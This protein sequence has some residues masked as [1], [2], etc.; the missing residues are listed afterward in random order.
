MGTAG[1]PDL[2]PSGWQ[3]TPTDPSSKKCPPPGAILGT[4]AAVNI[5]GS[6]LGVLFGHRKVIE[7][8]SCGVF[9]KQNSRS[10]IYFWTFSV[11]LQLAA[12]AIVAAIIKNTPGY[13]STFH[14]H[15]LVLLFAARPRLA[16]VPL[17]LLAMSGTSVDE[18]P[19]L[20]SAISQLFAECFLSI[21]GCLGMGKSIRFA[22]KA[23]DY[24][25]HRYRHFPFWAR[26]M[27]GSAVYYLVGTVFHAIVSIC[28]IG[29]FIARKS[30]SEH[31]RTFGLIYFVSSVL[32]YWLSSWLFWS[33]FVH[34]ARDR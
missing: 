6:A 31:I 23:M 28:A 16:W 2:L 22:A 32:T 5:A 9:G 27:Y 4:F 34:L 12:N 21:I 30:K 15:E 11:C 1:R 25:L 33:G 17:A 18:S 19:W 13:T 29:W 3:I 14:T 20:S 26:V 7:K 10:Y 24:R 8:L